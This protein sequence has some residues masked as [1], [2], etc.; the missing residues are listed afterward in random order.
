MFSFPTGQTITPAGMAIMPTSHLYGH[1]GLIH[2]AM[3]ILTTS[4]ETSTGQLVTAGITPNPGYTAG[5]EYLMFIYGI[6]ASFKM[7]KTGLQ[8]FQL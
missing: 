6:H 8:Y 1:A 4:T 3:P 2:S 5:N 7:L